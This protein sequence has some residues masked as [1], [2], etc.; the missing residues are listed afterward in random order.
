MA[1]SP[2]T[3][4]DNTWQDPLIPALIASPAHH[5]S[6][7]FSSWASFPDLSLIDIEF[8]QQRNTTFLQ[9]SH[10]ALTKSNVLNNIRLLK[11]C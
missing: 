2:P 5:F 10:E 4:S 7:G 11:V 8:S 6:P 9:H 1:S 3:N